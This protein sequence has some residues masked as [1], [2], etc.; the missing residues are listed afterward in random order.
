MNMTNCLLYELEEISLFL[1]Q[2]SIKIANVTKHII[3]ENYN[4]HF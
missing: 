1:L 3:A 4:I 2:S